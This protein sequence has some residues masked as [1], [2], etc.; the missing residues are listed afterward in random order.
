MRSIAVRNPCECAPQ[1]YHHN[2]S[3]TRTSL[4]QDLH[5]ESHLTTTTTTTTTTAWHEPVFSKIVMPN[6][7]ALRDHERPR[8]VARGDNH[9]I[10]RKALSANGV[11]DHD[12][13]EKAHARRCV[14]F[15]EEYGDG[16]AVAINTTCIF[17]NRTE[18]LHH[19]RDCECC[20][21]IDLGE[22]IKVRE[23]RVT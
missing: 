16:T 4:S 13:F 10:C 15:V 18:P 6:H 19:V 21:D 5:A 3:L 1:P 8:R 17:S 23:G 11:V 20:V 14:H 7:T 2:N 9:N 12:L 22:A